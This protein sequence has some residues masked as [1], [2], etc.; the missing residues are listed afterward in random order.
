MLEANTAAWNVQV[1]LADIWCLCCRVAWEVQ[2]LIALA[3]NLALS[4]NLH[5]DPVS[6]LELRHWGKQHGEE[7]VPQWHDNQPGN[8]GSM[9]SSV[10]FRERLKVAVEPLGAL[11]H[12]IG[13]AHAT[14]RPFTG[15]QLVLVDCTAA[16]C[17]A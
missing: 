16:T 7:R 3:R 12:T 11:P 2:D 4:A 10:D 17:T 9:E 15:K 13:S 5:P 8:L 14:V 6:H 1:A